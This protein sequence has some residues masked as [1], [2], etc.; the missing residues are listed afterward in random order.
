M[1]AL[2][3]ESSRNSP[4]AVLIADRRRTGGHGILNDLEVE[5]KLLAALELS[6]H[7]NS[8]P[9]FV[10]NSRSCRCRSPAVVKL[11]PICNSTPRIIS[12]ARWQSS[13]EENKNTIVPQTRIECTNSS[14]I[15]ISINVHAEQLARSRLTL[16][17]LLFCLKIDLPLVFTPK[18]P[19]L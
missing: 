9:I 6:N 2:S 4:G 18:Y 15:Y 11:F 12:F 5:D 19:N 17:Q 3:E 1:N 14:R 10:P 7:R 13:T 16:Y 8:P